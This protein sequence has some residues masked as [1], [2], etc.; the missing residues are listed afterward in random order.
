MTTAGP[1]H[2]PVPRLRHEISRTPEGR[3]AHA[4]DRVVAAG[5]TSAGRAEADGRVP[6]FQEALDLVR[7]R[8]GRANVRMW[9]EASQFDRHVR[10]DCQHL[11]QVLMNLLSN[12]VKYNRPGGTVTV[13]CAPVAGNRVKIAVADTGPGI[14][15]ELM[16][17]LFLPFERLGAEQTTLEGTGLGL[18]ISKRLVELMGGGIGAESEVGRGSTFWVDLDA[19][20]ALAGQHEPA[21]DTT[22]DVLA[23]AGAERTVLYVEDNLANLRLVER[24]LARRR[25]VRMVAAMQGSLALELAREHHPDLILLDVH[26][27]DI[28]GDEVLRRLQNDPATK[29]IPVITVSDEA[30]PAKVERF[31]A[32]GTPLRNQAVRRSPL[33]R[34]HRRGFEWPV[35]GNV[36]RHLSRRALRTGLWRLAT[37]AAKGGTVEAERSPDQPSRSTQRVLTEATIIIV[38]DHPP[39]VTLLEMLLR[40]AGVTRVYGITDPS[41]AVSRC[42]ELRPDLLLL[43]LHMPHLNGFEVMKALGAAL[44][45]EAFLPVLVLTA[46]VTPETKKRALAAGAKD[47]LTKPFD[48]TEVLLRVRNLLETR[49]LYTQVQRHNASLRA[50]IDRQ[51]EQARRLEAERAAR[52]RQVDAVLSGTALRMVFQPIAELGSG[53]IVG[54]EALARFE[55]EPR[56]PP[57]EWFAQAADVGLS[58]ELEFAAVRNALADLDLLPAETYMSVNVSP[59]ALSTPGL[60]DA[61]TT[62]P[63]GRL[64][65]E[66]TEHS[67]IETYEPLLEAL[68]GLRHLGVRSAVDDA[69]AGYAGLRHI[70]RLHPDIIKL[71]TELTRG[72][73][74]DPVRRALAASLLTFADDIGADIIAEGIETPEELDTLRS[75]GISWGQGY[76]LARPGPLPLPSPGLTIGPTR[77]APSVTDSAP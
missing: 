70:L 64:V 43:D 56:R 54:V 74:V 6:C 18:S 49:A 67:R 52:R 14:C 30:T 41:E 34:D 20:E 69:G 15:P 68:D 73:D 9:A 59:P 33:P 76:H 65:V 36:P 45:N 24:I 11:K 35:A 27:P 53:R 58:V 40:S 50:E 25:A 32:A 7:P 10:A 12:A 46:D 57:N 8:A 48:R 28:D 13:S 22:S 55:C 63:S 1:G 2:A 62:V 75:L 29:A 26:L 37:E 3:S 61:L 21:A 77:P 17:R 72:I 44:G 60:T 16:D 5:T 71:D 38:D 39:N 42:L 66:L 4:A 51:T 47:F 23:T 31:L 19:V